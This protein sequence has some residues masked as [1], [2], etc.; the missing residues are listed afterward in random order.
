MTKETNGGWIEDIPQVEI[1]LLASG[2]VHVTDCSDF[3]GRHTVTLHP[4]H[5][6]LIAERVGLIRAVGPTEAATEA[7]LRGQ[8]ADSAQVV[9]T[10]ARRMRA[11]EKR[12]D[13][14]G[15]WLCTHSDTAHADLT[16][17]QDYA[18]ATAEIC[19]EFCADLDDLVRRVTSV[20]LAPL[21]DRYSTV[22]APSAVEPLAP[23]VL[24]EGSRGGRQMEPGYLAGSAAQHQKE[25]A[26][27][28]SGIGEPSSKVTTD[29]A[30][31]QP[32]DKSSSKFVLFCMA[33]K[34]GDTQLCCASTADIAEMTGQD[35]KTV[36]ENIKRLSEFGLIVD[37]GEKG[38]PTKAIPV[39]RM[40]TEK[41]Y[42][43]PE[44]GQLAFGSAEASE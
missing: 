30:L 14:L 25:P 12:I 41:E 33:W 44:T 38:G 17:E 43:P 18:T 13:H 23:G 26:G 40:A 42:T 6:R 19:E 36:L 9:N 35:R 4:I 20:T 16:Y 29:W 28:A 5:L 31:R 15:N 27:V 22:T 37:T 2:S 34:S 24:W 10:L 21:P 1:E 32:L 3:D 11:L 7:V 8:L 39:F